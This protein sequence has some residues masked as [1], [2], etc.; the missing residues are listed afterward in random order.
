MIKNKYV[1][2][3]D[4]HFGYQMSLIDGVRKKTPTHCLPAIRAGMKFLQD[5]QPD[6]F[7]LGG[8]QLEFG[9]ISR[10]NNGQPRL[11][12]GLRLTDDMDLLDKH[13]LVPIETSYPFIKTKVWIKGNHENRVD[14]YLDVHPE[15]EG[16][17]EP[18]VYLNLKKR[19]WH[20]QPEEVPYQLGKLNFIHG[21]SVFAN[22]GGQNPAKK[23][24]YYFRRSMIAGHLHSTETCMDI[25]PA[26][27]SDFH[28]ATISG[29]M[30]GVSPDYMKGRPSNASQSFVYGYVGH[31]GSFN[32]YI[33]MIVNGRF[34]AEGKEY[35]G[36]K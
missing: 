7:I 3:Y 16:I 25:T 26:D 28:S 33:A 24:A 27:R 36:N 2:F 5:F 32:N 14:R 8:D 11:V 22:G 31:D 13:L 35:N 21:H 1:A 30:A 20:L 15:A 34:M 18:E 23:L 6:T 19:G 10:H 29:A 12:E 17:I 4:C 9:A